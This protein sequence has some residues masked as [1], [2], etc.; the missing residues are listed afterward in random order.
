MSKN[1]KNEQILAAAIR[2]LVS[3]GTAVATA[4]IAKEAGVS[5]GTLFNFY[6]TKQDLLDAVY[7]NIKQEVSDHIVT[8]AARGITDTRELTLHIW[9]EYILWAIAN[10]VK[11]Q[12]SSLLRSSQ[13]ISASAQESVDA[14]FLFINEHLEQAQRENC[15]RNLS[16]AFLCEI[17]AAQMGATIQHILKNQL[18]GAAMLALVNQSF[19][20]YWHGIK[21]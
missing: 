18:S 6:R 4:K 13:V 9:R 3:Q 10:P 21:V 15:I 20:I 12:A 1:I 11:Q 7:L 2:L 5:N 17:A 16:T 8:D 14:I 19:E